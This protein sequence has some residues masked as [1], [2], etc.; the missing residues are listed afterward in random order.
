MVSDPDQRPYWIG[1]CHMHTKHTYKSNPN[2]RD[3]RPEHGPDRPWHLDQQLLSGRALLRRRHFVADIVANSPAP[4]AVSPPAI[5]ALAARNP[6]PIA[7]SPR[8]ALKFCVPD[9]GPPLVDHLQQL[10]H[11]AKK[12]FRQR[13][14]MPRLAPRYRLR[15]LGRVQFRCNPP[16]NE[17]F[18]YDRA[19][20]TIFD[21]H[22]RIAPRASK[23]QR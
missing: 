19:R 3:R 5:P 14:R 22:G 12:P 11:L 9:L 1:G 7:P 15:F 10:I 2:H 20:P 6:T 13:S 17:E 8:S 4:A 21:R 23:T 16:S 18:L